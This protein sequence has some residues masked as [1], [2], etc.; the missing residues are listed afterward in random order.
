MP[1]VGL[2]E[3]SDRTISSFLRK[4]KIDFESDCTN[5][6]YTSMED[7]PVFPSPHQNVLSIELTLR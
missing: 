3:Y 6:N 4:H 2:A 1:R 7:V 5:K